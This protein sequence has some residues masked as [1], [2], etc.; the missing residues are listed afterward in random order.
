MPEVHMTVEAL[1][2][3]IDQTLLSP[4]VGLAEATAWIEENA[5]RGFAT[6]CVTP[7]FV[8][9]AARLL[10]GSATKVCSVCGFPLGYSLTSTKAEESRELVAL[11]CDEVDMVMS[12]GE[13]L[14]GDVGYVER[15]IRAVVDA[16]R[17]ESGGRAIVKVILETGH[18]LE[19]Q[20]ITACGLA[21]TAGADFVKTSTGFGPRGASLRD[22]E[23]MAAAVG[24][25]L[26]IK[27]A[28]GIRDVDSAMALVDAGA[29]RLGTS[30]G[31]RLLD[32]LA[33]RR[34]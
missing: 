14:G 3:L 19:E 16:A 8:S 21:E 28:G 15:D 23:L 11:G 10:D 31:A 27:A 5:D 12:V 24:G 26:G 25:R 2:G 33:A 18:L 6:L 7:L 29:T 32:E 17:G 34:A 4:T 20:V 13:L 9:T 22:V 30:S 1:A